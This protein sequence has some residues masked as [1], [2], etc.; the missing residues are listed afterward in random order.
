MLFCSPHNPVGRCWTKEELTALVDVLRKYQVI[1]VS[2]EIHADFVF[3]PSVFT[4]A[5]TLGYER[6]VALCAA[7]KTFN[8]AGLQQ[9]ACLCP[10]AEMREKV[11]KTVNQ[12]GAITGNI[13]A[14]TATRAAY[15]HGDAWLDGLVSYL[16]GNIREMEKVTA[17]LLPKAVL[18]PMEATYLAWLDL[19]AYGLS[20]EE[21]LAR[22]DKTGVIFT[23]GTFF[24]KELGDGFVRVN[25]ACPRKK[26][27]EGIRRLQAALN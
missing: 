24:S 18:T 9:S 2:D 12:T 1:L 22:C 17:E 6:T 11:Q 16:A 27:R 15:E 19:R 13:F 8:L 23:G 14:L 20:T 26:I 25:L 5:L 21:I 4:P 7:S 3:A 10:N